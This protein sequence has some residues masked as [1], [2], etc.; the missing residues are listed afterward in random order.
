MSHLR[1]TVVL[2]VSGWYVMDCLLY[3]LVRQLNRYLPDTYG[4]EGTK[5]ICFMAMELS[6]AGSKEVN[7]VVPSALQSGSLAELQCP[8]RGCP[9]NYQQMWPGGFNVNLSSWLLGIGHGHDRSQVGMIYPRE[10]F[11]GLLGG[12]ITLLF[13]SL[14]RKLSEPHHLFWKWLV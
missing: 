10:P 3:Q 8:S 2:F 1:K 14:H 12:T 13:N 6:I 5:D 4:N 9:L 11:L 7:A